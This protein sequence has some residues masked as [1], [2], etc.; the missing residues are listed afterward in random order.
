MV[1]AGLHRWILLSAGF[2]CFLLLCRILVTG[3]LTYL[4]LPWNLLLAFVPYLISGWLTRQSPVNGNRVRIY[5]ALAGW[6]LFV[7][8]SFY[9]ITDLFHLEHI[10]S[11]PPWFDLLMLFSFAWNGI[12][13]GLLSLLRVDQLIEGLFGKRFSFGF[14]IIVCWLNAW[15]IYI[16][17]YLRFNSWDV[18]TD[19]FALAGDML[20]M[21]LHPITHAAAW[22]MISCYAVFMGLL[23]LTF[24]KLGEPRPVAR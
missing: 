9:I 23:Y 22:G 4:F 2:S 1:T 11:A 5:L 18:L 12:L 24:K 19:P 8:N 6:L 20:N 10:D 21:I 3:R 17:R 13:F 15:G 14:L 16:G 7:P